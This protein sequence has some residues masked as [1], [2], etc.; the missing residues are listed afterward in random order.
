[1]KLPNWSA[2]STPSTPAASMAWACSATTVAGKWRS[3]QRA[4]A[5]LTSFIY[6]YNTCTCPS[7]LPPIAA[8]ELTRDD[9]IDAA[10]ELV[11]EVGYAGL[12]MRSPGRALRRGDHDALPPRAHQG[13]PAGRDRRSGAR[14]PRPA[15]AQE[16]PT[17]QERHPRRV[18]FRP[19]A[20][21]R[22][23]RAGRD[24]RP[25]ARG[26]RGRLP[27]RRGRCSAR[28]GGPGSRT[29]PR[30]APSP[31]CSPSPSAS[32]SSR[33]SRRPWAR[34]WPAGLL[35]MLERLPRSTTSRT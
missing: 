12:N 28:C 13:G 11:A 31:P 33:R 10:A 6:V 2:S 14:R 25:P 30:P 16:A 32:C 24:R 7:L 4:R 8:R 20:P 15:H 34:A 23:S 18:P 17:W 26:R 5:V 29:R 9:V 35:A 3:P 21:P 19:R 22:A 1:M 27:R